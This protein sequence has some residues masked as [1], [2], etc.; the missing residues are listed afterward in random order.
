[1]SVFLVCICVTPNLEAPKVVRVSD[2]P[3]SRLWRYVRAVFSR[4]PRLVGTKRV[5]ESVVRW[6]CIADASF[7][8]YLAILISHSTYMAN[9]NGMDLQ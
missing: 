1:M 6:L 4:V 9:S 5:F 3:P 7:R 2:D 8:A